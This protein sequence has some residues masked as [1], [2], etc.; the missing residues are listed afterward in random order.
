M[1]DAPILKLVHVVEEPAKPAA[2]R[3]PSPAPSK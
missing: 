2:A 1:G 3:A